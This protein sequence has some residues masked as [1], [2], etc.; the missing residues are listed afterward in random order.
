MPDTVVEI[1]GVGNIAFPDTMSHDEIAAASAKIYQE[2]QGAFEVKTPPLVADNGQTMPADVAQEYAGVK[3][4]Q[5]ARERGETVFSNAPTGPDLADLPIGF[6][7]GAAKSV[8]GLASLPHMIPGVSQATDFLQG[9]PQGASQANLQ[10]LRDATEYSNA[11]QNVGGK[12]E[13]LAEWLYPAAKLAKYGPKVGAEIAHVF[14]ASKSKAIES[15][16][17]VASSAA[18]VAVDMRDPAA[19]AARI[20]ELADRGG[21]MP[22]A[23]RDLL[24]RLDSG[25]VV[26]LVK[27]PE[28]RDFTSN[29]SRLS[30][31]ESMRLSPIIHAQVANLRMA[32]T[33][34]E[35]KAA[36]SVGKLSEYQAAMKEYARYSQAKQLGLK[37]WEGMKRGS[38]YAGGAA[39]GEFLRRKLAKLMSDD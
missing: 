10:T 3:E 12:L 34:A 14:G 32:L 18:N 4:R 17:D 1:P 31:N 37:I 33:A 29:V 24:K 27:Y 2:K 16:Q 13:G 6:A 21:S 28:S 30:A 35:A 22:K 38:P 23:V 19:I 39:A 9:N 11:T 26:N 7:K 8:I 5:Q 15:F 20:K 36:A 25:T